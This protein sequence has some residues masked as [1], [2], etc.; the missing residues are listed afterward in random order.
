MGAIGR[1]A[2]HAR[3]VWRFVQPLDDSEQVPIPPSV[4]EGRTVTVPERGEMFIREAGEDGTPIVLIHGWALTADLNWFSGIYE[5]AARHGRMVA[6][7]LRG[8]G[9][10]MRSDESFTIERAADD[11]AALVH[12]LDMAPAVLVGYSLGGSVALE[13]A[14]RHPE[15]VAGMVLVSTALQYKADVWERL[16]WTGLG[17]VEY[18]L[19]IGTPKGIVDRYLRRAAELSPDLEQFGGW[20]KGEVRRGDPTD[21]AA[22]GRSIGTFDFREFAGDVTVPTVSVIS[23]ND[24]MVREIRQRELAD[25]IPGAKTLELDGA[26]NAWMVKPKEF[27]TAIDEALEMVIKELS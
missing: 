11:V 19:R 9:R 26:H 4:P 7:D 1:L 22:A 25:A 10:G 20:I 14:K 18:G 5:V 8:H 17:V 24:L 16:Q 27:A 23:R 21:I 2:E 12:E 6:P 15:A 3:G 13:M